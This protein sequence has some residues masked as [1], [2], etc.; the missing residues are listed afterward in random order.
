MITGDIYSPSMNPYYRPGT[1]LNARHTVSCNPHDMLPPFQ[2]RGLELRELERTSP[3][4]DEAEFHAFYL[5]RSLRAGGDGGAGWGRGGRLRSEA[6]PLSK[7]GNC[8]EIS[9]KRDPLYQVFSELL[10]CLSC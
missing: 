2:M 10:Q 3:E 7:S 1:M 5:N 4:T 9:Q 6:L 8:L